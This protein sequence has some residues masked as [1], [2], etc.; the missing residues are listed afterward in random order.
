MQKIVNRVSLGAVHTYEESK[1]LEEKLVETPEY[2]VYSEEEVLNTSKGNI[3]SENEKI[4]ANNLAEFYAS[5]TKINNIN[6]GILWISLSIIGAGIVLIMLR[7][8]LKKRNK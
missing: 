4:K 5:E 2:E 6:I 1:K 7:K 3:V 8:N